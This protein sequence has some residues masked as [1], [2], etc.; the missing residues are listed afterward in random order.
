MT[1]GRD[2]TTSTL[3]ATVS[4]GRPPHPASRADRQ[5]PT[6]DTA[7]SK[8]PHGEDSWKQLSSP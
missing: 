4:A 7:K 8:R 2:I 1:P 6:T 5:F 3:T